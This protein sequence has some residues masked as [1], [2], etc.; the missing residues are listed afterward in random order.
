MRSPILLLCV[1]V[2]LAA[3]AFAQPTIP[4]CDRYVPPAGSDYGISISETLPFQIAIT[5][6]DEQYGCILPFSTVNEGYLGIYEDPGQTVLSDYVWFTNIGGPAGPSYAVMYLY[7][8]VEGV[9]LQPPVGTEFGAKVTEIG[10]EGSNYATYIAGSTDPGGYSG[11][12]TIHYTIYSDVPEPCTL[13][14][15]GAALLVVGLL[16]RKLA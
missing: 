10:V 13:L 8:D 2:G 7:S 6:T 16:K 11:S 1:L 15:A 3:M 4:P 9:P 5:S 14:L 12:G